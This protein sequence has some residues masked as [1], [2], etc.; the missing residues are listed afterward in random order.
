MATAAPSGYNPEHFHAGSTFVRFLTLVSC[1]A[2]C[3]APLTAQSAPAAP[4]PAPQ[5]ATGYG[6]WFGSIP[7][8]DGSTGGI[9]IEGTSVGSP[10][11]KAGLKAG[12]RILSIGG[13]RMEE[14]RSMVEVLRARQPG[15]TVEVV[16]QRRGTME[17]VKV[18][19]GVRPAS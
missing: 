2:L 1:I 4:P 10:A 13:V 14:L 3:I 19:L 7:N 18:I 5:T 17:K 15:D 16:Y 11:E 12:D 9:L 6:A 8:M